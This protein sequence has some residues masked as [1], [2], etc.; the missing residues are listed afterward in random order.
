MS[1]Q[2]VLNIC[3]LYFCTCPP[4]SSSLTYLLNSRIILYRVLERVIHTKLLE[5]AYKATEDPTHLKNQEH[6]Y[7][8]KEHPLTII[9][10]HAHIVLEHALTQ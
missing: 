7:N 1:P 10:E 3:Q 2:I 8:A 4:D 6:S 9:L 5:H